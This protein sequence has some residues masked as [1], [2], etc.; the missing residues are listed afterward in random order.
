MPVIVRGASSPAAA[1]RVIGMAVNLIMKASPEGLVLVVQLMR[2]A[3]RQWQEGR[4]CQS[5]RT[6]RD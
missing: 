3:F 1:S 6:V 5:R 2:R 4:E